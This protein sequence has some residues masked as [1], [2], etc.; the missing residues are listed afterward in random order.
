MF[1]YKSYN[2]LLS[3]FFFSENS[4]LLTVAKEASISG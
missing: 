1:V 4:L 2:T 3:V